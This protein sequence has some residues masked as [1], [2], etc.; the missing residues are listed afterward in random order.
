LDKLEGLVVQH[1]F[2]IEKCNLC[3]TGYK[4]CTSISKVLK[5]RSTT[6]QGALM[7]YNKLAWDLSW[8][9]LSFQEVLDYSFL[10][11]F[12]LLQ[13]SQNDILKQKWAS[14]KVCQAT[15]KWLHMECMKQEIK[16]L[17]VEIQPVWTSIHI[18]PPCLKHKVKEA[19]AQGDKL[20]TCKM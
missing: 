10:S 18:E 3:G 1:L 12:A 8:P 11:D 17:D 4:M 16:W 2:E 13:Y 14:P 9:M 6:I 5:Q 20:L 15:I 7:R 19:Q